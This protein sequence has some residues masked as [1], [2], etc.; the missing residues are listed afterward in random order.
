MIHHKKQGGSQDPG[1]RTGHTGTEITAV[2]SGH[3][4]C[5]STAHKLSHACHHRKETVAHSLDT[6]PI[7][8]HNCEGNHKDTDATKINLH[9]SNDFLHI[10][11]EEKI[12]QIFSG[13]NKENAGPDP[14]Q[15]A[16]HIRRPEAFPDPVRLPRPYS[17]HSR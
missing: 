1:H 13:K 12:G 7:N 10:L 14:V 8:I 4:G 9:V 5:G 6:V 16:L 17:G 11:R 3:E 2:M 15:K